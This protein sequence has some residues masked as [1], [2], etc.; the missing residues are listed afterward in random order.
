MQTA[1]APVEERR[2]RREREQRRLDASQ[3]V[4]PLD[5]AV[6]VTDADVDVEAER[7]V[8]PGD[9]FRPC[10]RGGSARSRCALLAMSPTEAV[11]PSATPSSS[12]RAKSS[13]RS[14]RCRAI[15]SAKSAPRP[16]MISISEEMSSPAMCSVCSAES[17]RPAVAP[18]PEALRHCPGSAAR[19]WRTPPRARQVRSL[20]AANSAAAPSR[21]IT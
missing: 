11:A 3:A 21:S 1:C 5:R 14:S 16:E 7:V 6:Q 17:A 12:A 8:A 19:G 9:C 15:A 20:A 2:A 4:A 10:C 13:Q 18:L